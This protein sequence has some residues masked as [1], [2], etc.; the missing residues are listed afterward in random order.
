MDSTQVDLFFEFA[1]KMMDAD[2]TLNCLDL[3]P[4]MNMDAGGL[5]GSANSSVDGVEFADWAVPPLVEHL[6]NRTSKT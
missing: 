6:P 4:G 2:P 3:D 5:D 1:S